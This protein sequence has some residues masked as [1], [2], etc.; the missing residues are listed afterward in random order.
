MSDKIEE[1]KAALQSTISSA[2]D[3][4]EKQLESYKKV[5]KNA[6]IAGGIVLGGYLLSRLFTSDDSPE[7]E[8]PVPPQPQPQKEDSI[9][10]PAIRGVATTVA[11]TLVRNKLLE[12]IENHFNKNEPENH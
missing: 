3:S 7:E 11:L 4:I 2:S 8:N 12:L 5:G 9:V 10:W 1:R 6:L